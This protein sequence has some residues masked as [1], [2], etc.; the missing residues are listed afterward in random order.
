MK[1]VLT[2]TRTTGMAQTDTS[3]VPSMEVCCFCLFVFF[4]PGYSYVSQHE[5]LSI[6]LSREPVADLSA[7]KQREFVTNYTTGLLLL[8]LGLGLAA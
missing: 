4:L 1:I 6:P 7:H 8:V 3:Q 5:H 2:H